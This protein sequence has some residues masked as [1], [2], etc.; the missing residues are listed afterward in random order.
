MG[1]A[2]LGAALGASLYLLMGY[3]VLAAFLAFTSS[4]FNASA[5]APHKVCDEIPTPNTRGLPPVQRGS[6]PMAVG[7]EPLC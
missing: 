1:A 7:A 3:P 6:T 5:A 4:P 2:R